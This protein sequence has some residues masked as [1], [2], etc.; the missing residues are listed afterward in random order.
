[1]F[2]TGVKAGPRLKIIKYLE[3][4][5]TA[6][7]KDQ[8]SSSESVRQLLSE[9]AGPSHILEPQSL[10]SLLELPDQ[11]HTATS[12]SQNHSQLRAPVTFPFPISVDIPCASTHSTAPTVPTLP[13]ESKSAP[14]I[15]IV[16]S[17]PPS[18]PASENRK[19]ATHDEIKSDLKKRK[20]NSVSLTLDSNIPSATSATTESL[21]SIELMTT[22]THT[23][24]PLTIHSDIAL[25]HSNPENSIPDVLDDSGTGVSEYV[26]SSTDMT[27]LASDG[28]SSSSKGDPYISR[29]QSEIRKLEEKEQGTPYTMKI[30]KDGSVIVHCAMCL[31]DLKLGERHK[32]FAAVNK[33]ASS[34]THSLNL[35]LLNPS[36]ESTIKIDILMKKYPD[37]LVKTQDTVVSCRVCPTKFNVQ[38]S[39][40][41]G[42]VR[43]HMNSTKHKENAEKKKSTVNTPK[44]NT[45]F[46]RAKPN[47]AY[48]PTSL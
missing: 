3:Q 22:P 37:M 21:V 44:I 48:I 14:P 42:N 10:G 24:S 5:R 40:F 41:S 11:S 27:R 8:S 32:Y 34:S 23:A 20:T 17:T 45:F 15:I 25:V 26:N 30:C 18:T 36:T 6:A 47:K 28:S 13:T 33:H 1:M 4:H 12:A 19:R 39:S 46:S 29:I 43:Q 31:Q 7:S 16:H 2:C 9:A 35:S 38:V